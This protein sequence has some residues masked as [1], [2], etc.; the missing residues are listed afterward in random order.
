MRTL[1]SDAGQGA[2][3]SSRAELPPVAALGS[4]AA[5]SGGATAL[6]RRWH[7]IARTQL[8]L[9]WRNVEDLLPV[10]VMP[11]LTFASMAI[12]LDAGRLDLIGHALTAC[13]L[14]TVGQMGFFVGSELV[15]ADR[16]DQLLELMVA[17]PTAYSITL[18]IRVAVIT[19]LGLLGVAEGWLIVRVIFGVRVLVAHP[20]VLLLTLLSS[21][22]AASGTAILFSALFGLARTTRTFQHAMNGPL[23]L[24]GG[25]LVPITFLPRWLQIFS[26]F[27]FFYWSAGLLRDSFRAGEVDRLWLRLG[28]VAAFGVLFGA[29]GIAVVSRMLYRLRRDGA[30][31]L[32]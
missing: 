8:R 27:T 7:V 3:E 14:I 23:Y 6:L 19:A 2:L 4:T 1:R 26:P 9:S 5:S 29:I 31:G 18:A 21:V 30:L 32:T 16:R 24:L 22:A 13:T 17:V 28:I 15:S 20:G 25:V 11:L 10:M 12:F